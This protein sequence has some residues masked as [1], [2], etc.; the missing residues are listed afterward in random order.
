MSSGTTL[1]GMGASTSPAPSPV[2]PPTTSAPSP[3]KLSVVPR[4][5]PHT[6]VKVTD[7]RDVTLSDGRTTTTFP[8]D[9]LVSRRKEAIDV[10]SDGALHDRYQVIELGALT[11]T[12]ACCTRLETTLGIGATQTVDRLVLAVERLAKIDIGEVKIDFTPGQLE[13]IAARAKKRGQTVKQSLMAVIDR[14][15]DELFWRS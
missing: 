4:Q 14:I 15:K 9:W 13:E 10:V 3:T 11:L 2:A 1:V 12:N 6:A 5:Q 8:G 7:R